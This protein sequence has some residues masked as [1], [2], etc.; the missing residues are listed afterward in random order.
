MSKML[1]YCRKFWDIVKKVSKIRYF[2][3]MSKE[4]I[5]HI[6]LVFERKLENQ[7]YNKIS[8]IIGQNFE[9][10]CTKVVKPIIFQNFKFSKQISNFQRGLKGNGWYDRVMCSTDLGW[11]LWQGERLMYVG[12]FMT[13]KVVI[14]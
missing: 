3:H 4:M 1:R 11:S 6:F 2:H 10:F 12:W 8:H 13:T 7:K 14:S 9:F 5:F